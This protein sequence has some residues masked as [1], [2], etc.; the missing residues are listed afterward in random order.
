MITS[1]GSDFTS[2]WAG[3]T[4]RVTSAQL[5]IYAD[6]L[7]RAAGVGGWQISHSERYE[8]ISEVVGGK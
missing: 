7:E 6:D 3:W 8:Q 5:P 4:A 2:C 1:R